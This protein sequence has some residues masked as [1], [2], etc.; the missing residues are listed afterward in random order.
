MPAS[1]RWPGQ[2]EACLEI[3]SLCTPRSL[4]VMD[5]TLPAMLLAFISAQPD[6]DN[7]FFGLAM[8]AIASCCQPIS[9][10]N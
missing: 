9:L 7:R 4:S 3:F 5:A 6:A 8:T 2:P 1:E 10:N